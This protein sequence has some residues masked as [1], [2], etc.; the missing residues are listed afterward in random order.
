MAPPGAFGAGPRA[1]APAGGFPAAGGGR[2][3]GAS[4]GVIWVSAAVAHWEQYGVSGVM[5]F[6]VN[7][8]GVVYQKDLGKNTAAIAQKM[9][10]FNPD[11]TWKQV[12]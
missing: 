10:R 6:I 5:T 12:G 9:T 3:C 1:G 4:G 2:E 11:S 8:D 7:Q